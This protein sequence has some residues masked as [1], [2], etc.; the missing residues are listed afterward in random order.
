MLWRFRI[1]RVRGAYRIETWD[2]EPPYGPAWQPACTGLPT[3]EHAQ[4]WL[5]GAPV[6]RWD[7]ETRMSGEY[8]FA[9]P[10]P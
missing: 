8:T 5:A 7:D 1:R 4:A 3:L 9:R 6:L 10:S 2:A